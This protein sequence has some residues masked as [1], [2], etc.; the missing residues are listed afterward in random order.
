MLQRRERLADDERFDLVVATNIF[1]YYDAFE[2]SMALSNV[3]AM[4]R[5]GGILLSNNAIAELPA[6][7]MKRAGATTVVYSPRPDDSDRILWYVR[8]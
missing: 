3:A 5:P 1:V 4:L 8:Q 7:P 2:Q 6:I